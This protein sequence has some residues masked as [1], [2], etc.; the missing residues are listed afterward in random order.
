MVARGHEEYVLYAGVLE[1][2]DGFNDVDDGAAGADAHVARSGIEMFLHG[3]L[4]GG[5]FGGL[6][7]GELACGRGGHGG[8]RGVESELWK[9]F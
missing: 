7:G 5:A 9:T 4:S 2:L 1:L 3:Q 6:D 8:E